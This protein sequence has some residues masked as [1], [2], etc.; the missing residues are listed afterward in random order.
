MEKGLGLLSTEPRVIAKAEPRLQLLMEL[1]PRH[2]AFLSN[3]AD[4]FSRRTPP[5]IKTTSPPGT[6]WADVFVP[7]ELPWKSFQESM[8]WHMVVLI[9]AWA[10]TQGWATRPEAA[11]EPGLPDIGVD[12]LLG[13][14]S[15]HTASEN[16]DPPA[17][18]RE[19]KK[20]GCGNSSEGDAGGGRE[21]RD[22][23]IARPAGSEA[24][25]RSS[26]A[27]PGGRT[28]HAGGSAVGHRTQQCSAE[29]TQLRRRA[30][31][32][33]DWTDQGTDRIAAGRNRGATSR[34][35][36]RRK[37]P[38]A[39]R[40]GI[41]KRSGAAAFG[42]GNVSSTG[43]SGGGGCVGSRAAAIIGFAR[44]AWRRT[45]R[46]DSGQRRCASASFD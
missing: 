7:T 14:K 21:S 4:A 2:E 32:G 38:H 41:G 36:R 6:F 22:A 43:K 37:R 28:D 12:L 17:E 31:A 39:A 45:A 44:I 42:G 24:G 1:E 46:I 11:R 3:L 34:R 19:G 40:A 9:A 33:R 13:V 35:A 26:S 20:H 5:P 29:W 16:S 10:L 30:S 15:L 23:Q 25:R 18:P 27:E 8:L